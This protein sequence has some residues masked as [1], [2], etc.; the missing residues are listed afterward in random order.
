M[1]AKTNAQ[2][3]ATPAA[4]VGKTNLKVMSYGSY[5]KPDAEGISRRGFIYAVKGPEAEVAAYVAH[6]K[7]GGFDNQTGKK[8][9][10]LL[11]SSRKVSNG[12]DVEV[13]ETRDGSLR[14]IPVESQVNQDIA[15]YMAQGDSFEF[16]KAKALG[17]I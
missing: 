9:E 6:Q 10:T 13:I 16:A 8:G 4:L 14:Y 7:A 17:Q 2:N 1:S 11:F 15:A 12:S 5:T 3:T